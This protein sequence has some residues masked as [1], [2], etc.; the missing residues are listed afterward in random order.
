MEPLDMF[1]FR[2][3][4][5][6]GDRLHIQSR[7]ASTVCGEASSPAE[8]G[9]TGYTVDQGGSMVLG[10]TPL[11]CIADAAATPWRIDITLHCLEMRGSSN[12]VGGR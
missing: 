6:T 8:I 7:L 2:A 9:G 12:F 10:V 5:T 3:E 1:L 4:Y 11:G